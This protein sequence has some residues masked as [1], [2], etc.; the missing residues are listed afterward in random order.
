MLTIIK[1]E[2][3]TFI[4]NLNIEKKGKLES[5]IIT[6]VG[7]LQLQE[8][9]FLYVPGWVQLLCS[10]CSEIK[11]DVIFVALHCRLE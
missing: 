2:S 4:S 3:E 5:L 10:N 11:S 7:V 9:K 8:V 6:Q 1:E